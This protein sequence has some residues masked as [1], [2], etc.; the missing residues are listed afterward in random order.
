MLG[1]SMGVQ[2][3]LLVRHHGTRLM[4]AG[5]DQDQAVTFAGTPKSSPVST[6]SSCPSLQIPPQSNVTATLPGSQHAGHFQGLSRNRRSRG[7]PEPMFVSP[8]TIRW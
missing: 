6:T 2:L 5:K 8:S 7:C 3:A 1:K 4:A